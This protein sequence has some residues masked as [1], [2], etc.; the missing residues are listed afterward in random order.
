MVLHDKL[1]S[2]ACSVILRV[3]CLRFKI[4]ELSYDR[5]HPDL[6]HVGREDSPLAASRL[7]RA[8]S[9]SMSAAFDWL[10]SCQA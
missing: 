4:L 7:D 6:D 8:K 1:C 3:P 9:A 2:L 10:C 5:M